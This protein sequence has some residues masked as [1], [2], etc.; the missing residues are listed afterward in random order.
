MSELILLIFLNN[1][2]TVYK[3]KQ[4]VAAHLIYTPRS[5]DKG[6]H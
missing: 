2:T 6:R 4:R 5:L 1:Y 3:N